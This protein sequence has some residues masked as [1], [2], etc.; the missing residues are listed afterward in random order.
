MQK[1]DLLEKIG[2]FL[3]AREEKH[4]DVKV[5][6]DGQPAGLF[7]FDPSGAHIKRNFEWVKEQ[8]GSQRLAI[9]YVSLLE[10]INFNSV[11]FS[12]LFM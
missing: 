2:Q 3:A 5:I 6:V 4:E 12:K 9:S 11:E 1:T 7:F 10:V 8:L